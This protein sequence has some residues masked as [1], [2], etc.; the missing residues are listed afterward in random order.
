M[1]T[2]E[3]LRLVQSSGIACR[4]RGNEIV[5]E[6]C[7]YC[8]NAKWNLELNSARAVFYCWACRTGG[9]LGA[10]VKQLTGHSVQIHA[11]PGARRA[12]KEERSAEDLAKDAETFASQRVVDSSVATAYCAARG[13]TPAIAAGY[14]L[15]VCAEPNHRLYG[16]LAVPALDFWTSRRIGWQGRTMTNQR[17][18]YLSTMP[19]QAV[20][21]WRGAASAPIVVVE[22][23]FDGISAHR[24][25][26]T[27]AVL[28]GVAT[29]DATAW[30]A[31]LPGDALL[32]IMLDGEAADVA[33]K[34][35]WQLV[36]VVPGRVA[37]AQLP[38][39]EDPASI[40]PAGVAEYLSAAWRT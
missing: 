5:L 12:K 15:V 22:G 26:C 13:L 24:A 16:R 23:P 36:E 20:F 4:E 7:C 40:G 38:I 25:G 35:Y 39:G 28:G 14:G 18:K 30:A 34:L 31:R 33:A 3:L 8:G 21:G 27:A 17:P 1:T 37:F 19:K 10:A 11:D 2:E 9:P 6:V 32:T 29:P